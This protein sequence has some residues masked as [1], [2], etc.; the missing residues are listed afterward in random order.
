MEQSVSLSQEFKV[1]LLARKSCYS[2]IISSEPINNI[3]V[4]RAP[5]E[6]N[7]IR[8]CIKS[9]YL[10]S[11]LPIRNVFSHVQLTMGRIKS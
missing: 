6:K 9:R 4:L 8:G 7:H 10:D 1:C 2:V 11:L 3:L 5:K